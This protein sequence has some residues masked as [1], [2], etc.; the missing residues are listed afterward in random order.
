MWP[1]D[2]PVLKI[3]VFAEISAGDIVCF[4]EVDAIGGITPSGKEVSEEEIGSGTGAVE[5]PRVAVWSEGG[6]QLP[7]RMVVG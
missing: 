7:G 2:D 1:G 4:S 3:A 6:R 5:I